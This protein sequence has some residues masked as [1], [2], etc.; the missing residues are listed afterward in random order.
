[1]KKII[2]ALS[3][4]LLLFA[5]CKEK[6]P[7]IDFGGV[8]AV[9]STYT[10]SPV[11]GP[12]AHNVLI[13]EFTGQ[14]CANCPA[15]HDV[16]ESIAHT[17]DHG[18]VNIIGLYQN[19]GSILTRP[20]DGALFD[21]RSETANDI[22]KYVS[23]GLIGSIPMAFIDRKANSTGVLISRTEWSNIVTS[24]LSVSGSINLSV[25]SKYDA[26][27]N[28]ATIKA[29]VVYTGAVTSKQNLN[30]VIVEDSMIDKQDFPTSLF[31]PDGINPDYIFTNVFRDM[32]SLAPAGNPI[33]ET[34]AT[35]PAGQAYWRKYTYKPNA[36][37][38]VKNCKVIAFIANSEGSDH[39]VQQSAQVPLAP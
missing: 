27:S 9:D 30:V 12:E 16:L 29:T 37:Y 36:A 15:G 1:M 24:Q 38:K 10:L 33:L 35:K 2:I 13:E 28:T 34:M 11:P 22:A 31:P 20:P 5:G 18:R 26:A 17:N 3:S 4:G 21:F 19:D 14:S 23:S 6:A 25:E 7:F 39:Y 8:A 32:V